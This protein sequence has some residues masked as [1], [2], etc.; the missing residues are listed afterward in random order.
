MKNTSIE[1]LYQGYQFI[2]KGYFQSA[3]KQG[4][5]A[6]R[7]KGEQV[8]H[9]HKFSPAICQLIYMGIIELYNNIKMLEV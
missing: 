4:L 2:N 8:E 7:S 1:V 5:F 3:C 9:G 6:V